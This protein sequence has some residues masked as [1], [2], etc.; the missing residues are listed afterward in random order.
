MG[1]AEV[2]RGKRSSVVLFS[3]IVVC[4]LFQTSLCGWMEK[5]L[6]MISCEYSVVLQ[7]EVENA[8]LRET[9]KQQEA[10]ILELQK[11]VQGRSI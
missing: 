1:D 4:N 5:K 3:V 8:A 10:R 2:V 6:N 7:F 9:N 11:Q